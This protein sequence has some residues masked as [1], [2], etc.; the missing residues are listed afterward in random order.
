MYA[1]RL[2]QELC[3]RN[4]RYASAQNLAHVLSYGEMPVVVYRPEARKHGNFLPA[5]YKAILG[6]PEW[7]RRLDKVHSQAARSL[8]R[9]ENGWRQLDSCMSSDALLMNVFCHPGTA[10]RRA[11]QTALAL[12]PGETPLFG[13]MAR[14]PLS[15]GRSD[16]T[17]ID[18]KCGRV[19]VEA[20]LTEG[21][22]QVKDGTAVEAYRHLEEV[23]DTALLPRRDG[24]YLSYQLIRNVLAAHALAL[25]FCV[26][27]DARRPDL[28]EACYEIFRCV[29]GT[30][31]R[32]RCKVLTW[33]ELSSMLS[34]E[35]RRFLDVKYGI[36]PPGDS[37]S[38]IEVA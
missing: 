21:D 1:A 13:F 23:F 34:R 31:L 28:I 22:F 7:R 3:A 2:R 11:V 30:E 29:R 15:S 14:V 19:L 6:N 35:L 17:E 12:E 38:E 27:L 26:L 5:S 9:A 32:T 4:L 25:D 24:Q 36:V 18:M 16:R 8:P 33:Q 20:K 37:A 10:R